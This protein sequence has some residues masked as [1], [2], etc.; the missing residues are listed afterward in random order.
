MWS[1]ANAKCMML[2]TV[3]QLY[4][5]NNLVPLME[6][7]AWC[8]TRQIII[9]EGLNQNELLKLIYDSK[10]YWKCVIRTGLHYCTLIS[11]EMC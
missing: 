11:T 1:Y 9:L 2:L 10:L 8:F 6:L 7:N 5:V 4:A 3:D